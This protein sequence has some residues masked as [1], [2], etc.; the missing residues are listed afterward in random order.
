MLS[1]FLKHSVYVYEC[2]CLDRKTKVK[3]D[4]V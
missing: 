4:C 3:A 1:N 2:K